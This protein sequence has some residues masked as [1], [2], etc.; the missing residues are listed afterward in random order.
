M[1]ADRI[2]KFDKMLGRSLKAHTEPVPADFTARMLKQLREA[3]EQKILARVILQEKL[4]LAG[5]II[6]GIVIIAVT[7]A[8]P[9]IAPT[10]AGQM[11]V[12]TDKIRQIIE[13]LVS[14]WQFYMVFAGV[15]VFAIYSLADLL[16]ADS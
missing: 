4:A 13:L 6:I 7:A 11:G 14:R 10:L 9:N 3:E 12:L 16:L 8:L 5:C 1:S 2:D 15:F